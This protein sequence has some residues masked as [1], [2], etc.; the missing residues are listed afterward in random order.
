L[1][2]LLC[3]KPGALAVVERPRPSPGL[4]EVLVRVR[5]AGVCGT[6]LHI[7]EGSHPFLEYPRV[8]GHELSGEVTETGPGCAI[9]VGQKVFVI[10]Y[11]SCGSCVACRRGKTNCC[12]RI[13][14]LGVHV[15][16][17]MADFVCVPEDNVAAADG[18]TLDQA[19][20]VEFLAIG[21]HAVRRANPRAGDRILVVGAGPIGAGCMI[22]AK[23]RGGSVTALDMRQDRLGFC[24]DVLGV[25]HTAAAGA[26]TLETLSQ[27]T[28]DDFFDIV[29][30]ATGNA[31]SMAAGFD[32]VAHGGTYVL[33]SV[34]RDTISFSDPKFHAR[35]TSLLGSRNATR[36]DFLEVFRAMRDGLVP[37]DALATHRASLEESPARFREWIRP[38][39]GVIK[40]L[41]E[42]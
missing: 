22:F 13:A 27:L 33:V 14:V 17:G 23:L 2:A 34:V 30:D 3:V 16:G 21:A 10:P 35:E 24:R 5:R 7:Y 32:Y 20:M 38:E 41:I 28:D 6:D 40:A 31:S 19:A 8:I 42:I 26:D 15:D 9:A 29:I 11:L 12:Q 4:G 18:V 36:E 1:R 25:D 39:T 37:T